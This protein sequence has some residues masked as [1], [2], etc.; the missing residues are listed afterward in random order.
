MVGPVPV[1]DLGD[2]HAPTAVDRACRDL[3]FLVVRGHGADLDIVQDCWAAASAFFDRPL[4]DRMAA[5]AGAGHPYGYHPFAA[6][7]L[8]ASLGEETPP[9]LKETFNVGPLDTPD[10]L[11]PQAAAFAYRDNAWP[12]GDAAFRQA[13]EAY[14]REMRRVSARLLTVFAQALGLAQDHFAPYFR[15]PM[16]ALRVINYPEPVGSPAAGQLRAGAHTDY[17]TLT[18]LLQQADRSGLQVLSRG[19]WHDVPALPGTLVVNI[20]DLMAQWTNNAW[21]STLHRVVNPSAGS[22]PSRRQSLVFFHTPDWDAEIRCLPGCEAD[23]EQ[24]APVQA[25]P[26]LA[27]KFA[28]TV[29][30]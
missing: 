23:G 3:G 29:S 4:A 16:S 6:E 15:Q 19:E 2:A 30:T 12:P 8:A 25:G 22:G 9:D 26:H 1:V 11:D 10:R 28:A 21:V 14:Y 18:L 27:A 7:A 5:H 20:G 13:L 17:G 24:Y